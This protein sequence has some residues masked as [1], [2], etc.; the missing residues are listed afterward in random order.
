MSLTEKIERLARL[1]PGVAGYQDKEASRD[2][3]K[4]IRLHLNAELEGIK[5]ELEGD[6]RRLMNGKDLSLLPALDGLAAK[7]DK[8]GNTV[9]YAARGYSGVFDS[10][11]VDLAK[12]SEL[13]D[14][15]LRLVDELARLKT[16]GQGIRE[17]HGRGG[18]QQQAIDDLSNALDQFEKTFATRQSKFTAG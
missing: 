8:L 7:L 12:L 9:K 13:C 5:R 3:D 17:A 14:F 6:K 16:L 15:D 10:D 11:K 1:I 2:A 18:A 4:N